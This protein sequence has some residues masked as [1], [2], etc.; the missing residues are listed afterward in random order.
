MFWVLADEPKNKIVSRNLDSVEI[1]FCRRVTQWSFFRSDFYEMGYWNYIITSSA[2]PALI[3]VDEN[4]LS[5]D[6]MIQRLAW[7]V[8]KRLYQ[9]GDNIHLN[10][11]EPNIDIIKS[12]EREATVAL[13]TLTLKKRAGH[14]RITI[15]KYIKFWFCG[16]VKFYWDCQLLLFLTCTWFSLGR[17]FDFCTFWLFQLVTFTVKAGN[18]QLQPKGLLRIYWSLD[19]WSTGCYFSR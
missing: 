18:V 19:M 17:R 3:I 12:V 6:N 10:E 2:C 4:F 1:R 8:W 7:H 5:F 9:M 14:S 11:M 13:L 16:I 15:E